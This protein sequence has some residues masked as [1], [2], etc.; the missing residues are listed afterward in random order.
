MLKAKLFVA[1]EVD[2]KTTACSSFNKVVTCPTNQGCAI[3]SVNKVP[4]C[5]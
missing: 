2:K 1:A 5:A 4:Y 3:N